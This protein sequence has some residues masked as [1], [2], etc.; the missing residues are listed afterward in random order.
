MKKHL[1]VLALWLRLKLL[2]GLGIMAL[3]VSAELVLFASSLGRGDS[4]LPSMDSLLS[5]CGIRHIFFIAFVLLLILLSRSWAKARYTLARL[6]LREEI[7]AVWDSVCNIG[8]FFLLWGVQ[9]VAV[10]VMSRWYL[11]YAAG[12][13][14]AAVGAQT[15][16]LAFYR[17]SFLH[18]LLPLRHGDVWVSNI[19]LFTAAGLLCAF[20]SYRIRRGNKSFWSVAFVPMV[21]MSLGG[22]PSWPVACIVISALQV[23]MALVRLFL[24]CRRGAA[25]DA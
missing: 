5:R 23:V 11:E 9:L 21:A 15:L 16:V 17:D 22:G 1:S 24:G 18:F 14:P 2:P 6:S 20:D 19:C 4:W 7:G 12:A 13:D 3:M 8:C 25:Q 10:L